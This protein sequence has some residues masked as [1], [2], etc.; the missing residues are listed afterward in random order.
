M[1]S[2]RPVPRSRR[3]S[4]NRR[5]RNT[6][7][8]RQHWP[9]SSLICT[10]SSTVTIAADVEPSPPR[11]LMAQ[12]GFLIAK[13]AQRASALTEAAL[14]PLRLSGRH[15]G[16]IEAVGEWPGSTQ[17]ALADRLR[18]DRTTMAQLVDELVA[19][20]LLRRDVH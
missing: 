19:L 18:L 12:P 11:T 8:G 20:R 15:Y 5:P 16:V 4:S 14:A 17:Q 2:G 6:C 10:R 3:C 9:L 7:D 13:A 1:P